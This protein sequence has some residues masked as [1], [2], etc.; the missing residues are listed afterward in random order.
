MEAEFVISAARPEQFPVETLPEIAFLGRSNV[1]K[2]SLLNCLTGQRGL[3][4]TSATPGCTQLINFYRVGGQFHFVDLPGYGFARVP[5]KVTSQWKQLIE[6]YLLNRRSLELCFL[7]LD[8]RRGWMEQD[9][10]LRKWLGFHNR[11]TIAIATKTD[12]LKNQKEHRQASEVWSKSPDGAP[13][14]F[15][16]VQCRGVREIWQAIST[17]KTQQQ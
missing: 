14:P 4:I 7:V 15:S 16:A 6:H 2:S 9:L 5:K 13:L 12:K 1:G 17:I 3:A 11:R 10:E 8:A